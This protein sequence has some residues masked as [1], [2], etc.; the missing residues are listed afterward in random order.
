MRHLKTI[1]FDQQT[2]AA[3]PSARIEISG[4][5]RAGLTTARE[6]RIAGL[7]PRQHLESVQR[8]AMSLGF[9]NTTCA[10]AV[11]VAGAR[12]PASDRDA[13]SPQS[14]EAMEAYAGVAGVPL[15]PNPNPSPCGSLF[16]W[17][18]LRR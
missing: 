3:V 15:R 12:F 16:I 11:L 9:A 5:V 7:E 18:R 8:G 4:K 6:L 2:G 17:T 14:V 1:L 10:P 13:L